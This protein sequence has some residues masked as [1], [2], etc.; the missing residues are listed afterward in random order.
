MSVLPGSNA[1]SERSIETTRYIDAP[2]LM[3]RALP[4]VARLISIGSVDIRNNSA[5]DVVPAELLGL[6]YQPLR[7]HH[8]YAGQAGFAF[9]LHSVAIEVVKDFAENVGA[10][11]RWIGRDLDRGSG[12]TRQG[13]TGRIIH[14]LRAVYVLALGDAGTHRQQ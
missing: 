14:R 8:A 2:K 10:I 3:L 4:L 5:G 1:S 13:S 12:F 6:R 7:C 9:V 11:E